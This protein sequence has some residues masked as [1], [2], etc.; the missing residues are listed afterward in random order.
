MIGVKGSTN[1]LKAPSHAPHPMVPPPNTMLQMHSPAK[2]FLLVHREHAEHCIA[3]MLSID[4]WYA[5]YYVA[6][7]AIMAHGRRTR[8]HSPAA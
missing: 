7:I 8:V 5:E 6:I 2:Q 3:S 1:R 4:C